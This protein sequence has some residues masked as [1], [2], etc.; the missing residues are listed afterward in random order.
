LD[1]AEGETQGLRDAK[2]TAKNA[3]TPLL[4]SEGKDRYYVK[5]GAEYLA[6]ENLR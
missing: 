2:E 1:T 6:F 5:A 4:I 3:L